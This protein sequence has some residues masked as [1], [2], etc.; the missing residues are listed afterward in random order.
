MNGYSDTIKIVSLE[1]GWITT[2]VGTLTLASHVAY[3]ASGTSSAYITGNLA[4]GANRNFTVNDGSAADDLVISANIS[5]AFSVTKRS[6][7]VTGRLV[8]SGD[9]SYTG[10]T[11]LEGGSVRIEHGNAL[12]TTAA[13]TVINSGAALEMAGGISVGAEA[14]TLSGT[15]ISTGG[16]LLNT[17][18]NNSW[19]G[20]LTLAAASTIG[21]DAGTL[22]IG[23][24]VANGGFLAT[25]T[26]G[27]SRCCW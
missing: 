20:D 19:A 14:L 3:S 16:A 9:N 26:G 12:G 18:G 4:L 6:A 27:A 1:G 5:G 2:G 8:L 22:T 7:T 13:G 10:L 23:S 25:F 11:T 15:G 21:S 17:S 24:N